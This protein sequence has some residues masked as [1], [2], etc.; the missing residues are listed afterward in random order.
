MD[1]SYV[2]LG[3]LVAFCL[4]DAILSPSRGL[5]WSRE[6]KI[7]RRRDWKAS[8]G[9]T[10]RPG[11]VYRMPDGTEHMSPTGRDVDC[12]CGGTHGSHL[13]QTPIPPPRARF[14]W[15]GGGF[16]IVNRK[17][18]SRARIVLH[19]SIA[20]RMRAEREAGKGGGDA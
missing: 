13:H 9:Y 14:I 8:R 7:A 17:R 5:I 2:I 15:Q 19:R 1:W 11:Y 4:W 16:G 6:Q 3:L 20:G 10:M 12:V 18:H